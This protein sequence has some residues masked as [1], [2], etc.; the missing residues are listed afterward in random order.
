MHVGFE[1]LNQIAHFRSHCHTAVYGD[2]V[3]YLSVA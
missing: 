3:C 2:E 1:F